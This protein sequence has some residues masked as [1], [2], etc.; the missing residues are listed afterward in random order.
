MVPDWF[1]AWWPA[2]LSIENVDPTGL[3][4]FVVNTD[5]QVNS[6]ATFL[7]AAYP[8]VANTKADFTPRMSEDENLTIYGNVGTAVIDING[9]S[10][11]KEIAASITARKGETG[12]YADAQTRMNV[13]FEEMTTEQTDK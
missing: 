12:V 10:T 9:G 3:G 1:P 2:I 13:S 6:I 5:Q 8:A 4:E 7:P 11:A